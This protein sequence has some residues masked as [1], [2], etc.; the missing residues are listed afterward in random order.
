MSVDQL[1]ADAWAKLSAEIQPEV[2]DRN[3]GYLSGLQ[4]RFEIEMRK[5]YQ[6]GSD[7]AYD[8][9]NRAT[10]RHSYGVRKVG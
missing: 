5:A 7:D 9:V 4:V 2:T 3:R 8:N 10:L 6:A 1:I